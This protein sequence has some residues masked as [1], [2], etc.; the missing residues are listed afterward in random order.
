M[1][2]LFLFIFVVVI[3]AFSEIDLLH[4]LAHFI[5]ESSISMND[6]FPGNS[7]SEEVGIRLFSNYH[8]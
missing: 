2:N 8:E 7:Y 3:V 5:I 6:L 4:C 1:Y